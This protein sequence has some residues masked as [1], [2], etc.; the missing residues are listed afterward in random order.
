MKLQIFGATLLTTLGLSMG[1]PPS[2]ARPP[3]PRVTP[4]WDPDSLT[5][6]NMM[7]LHSTI[8]HTV[9]LAKSVSPSEEE[10]L[11]QMGFRRVTDPAKIEH[12]TIYKGELYMVYMVG[13]GG[14]T[15]EELSK[16][17]GMTL[18]VR[19]RTRQGHPLLVEA[20]P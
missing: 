18:K 10:D 6:V 4:E 9:M 3:P 8:D 7:R 20:R 11:L 1:A 16:L 12:R 19:M 5:P 2:F 15:D 14:P 13:P 17:V